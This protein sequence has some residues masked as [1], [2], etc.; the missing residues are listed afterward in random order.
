MSTET[1][2]PIE[3]FAQL[4]PVSPARLDELTQTAEREAIFARICARRATLPTQRRGLPR[5]S[6]A[7]ATVAAFALVV[8]ALALS[9][10][11]SSL[12]GFSNQGTPVPQGALSSVTGFNLSGATPGSLVQLAARDGVGVYGA[13]TPNGGLCYFVGPADKSNVESQGLGGGCMNAAVSA[14]FPS[15]EQPVVDMSLFALKPGTAGPS[16]QRLAGVAADGV[17]SVQVLA[18]SDCHVVATAPV[19]DNVYVADNLPLIPEAEIVARDA[20]GTA[21]WHESV[22]RASDSSAASC[23]LR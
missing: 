11:L 17:T 22:T 14:R 15:T 7:M 4:N 2:D 10:V 1:I 21:V 19:T 18:L 6:L 3:L 20:S 12:F 5:R 9:G 8:P 13:K 16:V 23:G